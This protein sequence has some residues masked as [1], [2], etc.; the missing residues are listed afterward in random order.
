MSGIDVEID[1]IWNRLVIFET[2]EKSFHGFP[3]GT[4]AVRRS[5][6]LY[7]YTNGRERTEEAHLTNFIETHQLTLLE[8]LKLF[9]PPVLLI[10]WKKWFGKKTELELYQERQRKYFNNAK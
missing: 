4:N 10:L 6:A 2:D 1:P 5:L 8:K 3:Q 7:Y 9:I